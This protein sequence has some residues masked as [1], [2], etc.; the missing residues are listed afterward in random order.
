MKYILDDQLR[1]Q[2]S[3]LEIRNNTSKFSKVYPEK[4]NKD[5]KFLENE[6]KNWEEIVENV[7]DNNDYLECERK[8]YLFTL[9][10]I[11]KYKVLY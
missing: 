11:K 9:F 3:K 1:W 4:I 8:L 5:L 7:K 6:I 2:Y 10:M